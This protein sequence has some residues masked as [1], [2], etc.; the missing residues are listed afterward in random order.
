[1]LRRTI[2]LVIAAR[3]AFATRASAR[4][5]HIVRALGR[6]LSRVQRMHAAFISVEQKLAPFS[7]V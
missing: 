7:A 3:H 2:E 1:L 6:S 4:M 5:L